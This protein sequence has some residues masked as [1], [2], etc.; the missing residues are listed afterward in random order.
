MFSLVEFCN[1]NMLKGTE[2][3]F[4]RLEQA[5]GIDCVDYECTNN[6]GLCSKS[7]FA[8]VDGELVS[9]KEPDKLEDKIYKR[10]EKQQD[11][12]DKLYDIFDDLK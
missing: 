7:F 6:C 5:E 2:E 3:V 12:Q 4:K 11:K 10:I 8:L 1:S 9:A